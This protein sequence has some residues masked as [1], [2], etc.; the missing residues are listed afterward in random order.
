MTKFKDI[1]KTFKDA[2]EDFSR[3]I[4]NKKSNIRATVILPYH[5]QAAKVLCKNIPRLAAKYPIFQA[6]LGLYFL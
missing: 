6:H 1:S 5:S 3:I 4:S 2:R